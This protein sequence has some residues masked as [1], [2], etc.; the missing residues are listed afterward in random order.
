VEC[1]QGK[2]ARGLQVEPEKYFFR[3]RE[4]A[5]FLGCSLSTINR[6]EETG[7]L[8]PRQYVNARWCGWKKHVLVN[9]FENL[10]KEGELLREKRIK[11]LEKRKQILQGLGRR[12]G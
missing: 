1:P 8:P 2:D 6:L 5:F 11:E 7:K 10:L 4:A 12:S 3:P 9:C